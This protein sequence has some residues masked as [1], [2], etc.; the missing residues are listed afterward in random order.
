MLCGADGCIG[1]CK[2]LELFDDDEPLRVTRE[3]EAGSSS[4]CKAGSLLTLRGRKLNLASALRILVRCPCDM[5]PSFLSFNLLLLLL[6]LD[7]EEALSDLAGEL[8]MGVTAIGSSRSGADRRWWRWE[9]GSRRRE[10]GEL[11]GVTI[12][13]L[14][15]E[16][17]VKSYRY[18]HRFI[19]RLWGC[20]RAYQKIIQGMGMSECISADYAGYGDVGVHIIQA[21]GV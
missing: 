5:K 7:A 14:K 18:T 19:S 20:R 17:G 13:S 2:G 21:S 10:P 6:Y 9:S 16:T 8:M 11:S 4:W 3:N 15:A 1:I 12:I